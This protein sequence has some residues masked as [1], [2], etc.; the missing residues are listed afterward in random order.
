MRHHSPMVM[1]MPMPELASEKASQLIK[2]VGVHIGQKAL[3]VEIICCHHRR[4]SLMALSGWCGR[5]SFFPHM[6]IIHS[7]PVRYTWPAGIN[8]AVW[9]SLP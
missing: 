9:S 5:N 7:K 6:A 3:P 8:K 1:P 4:L 2:G